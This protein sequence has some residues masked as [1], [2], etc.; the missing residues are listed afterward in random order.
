MGDADTVK[1]LISSEALDD[2]D[3]KLLAIG[4]FILRE[5]S[6][7]HARKAGLKV[8]K[9]GKIRMESAFEPEGWVLKNELLP[10]RYQQP[11]GLEEHDDEKE[12]QENLLGEL[13]VLESFGEVFGFLGEGGKV[14]LQLLFIGAFGEE[15]AVMLGK[16][17][18][19]L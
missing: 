11:E 6:P 14:A 8:L 12:D 5:K 17:Y 15:K 2:T 3:I 13:F 18:S 19:I 10:K 4:L 7:W 16:G 1:K 9:G